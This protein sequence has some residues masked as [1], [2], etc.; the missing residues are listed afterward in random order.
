MGSS[1]W[2]IVGGVLMAVG[3]VTGL[4]NFIISPLGELMDQKTAEAQ[5]FFYRRMFGLAIG[6]ALIWVGHGLRTG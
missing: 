6:A 1:P 4:W 5:L 3:I 2:N